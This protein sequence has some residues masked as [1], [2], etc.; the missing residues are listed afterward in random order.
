MT[1]RRRTDGEDT[2][3]SSLSIPLHTRFSY[4]RHS[5]F[6][7]ISAEDNGGG[8]IFQQAAFH[9]RIMVSRPSFLFFL[10]GVDVSTDCGGIFNEANDG[11]NSTAASA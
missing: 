5:S 10:F 2:I 7:K 9:T 11:S 3:K 8:F 4:F 6:G 1:T